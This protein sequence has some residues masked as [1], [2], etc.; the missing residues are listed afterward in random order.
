MLFTDIVLVSAGCDGAADIVFVFDAS[1]SIHRERFPLVLDFAKQIITALEVNPQ[2]T[3]VAAVKWSNNAEAEFYLNTYNRYALHYE[4]QQS[5]KV[6]VIMTINNLLRCFAEYFLHVL[7]SRITIAC[8]SCLILFKKEVWSTL[9]HELL[10][11]P[12]P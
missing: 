6:V 7:V 8:H 10:T 2:R 5:S 9:D 12:S 1:G 11:C 3:R 4:V